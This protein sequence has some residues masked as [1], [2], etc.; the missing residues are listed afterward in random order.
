MAHK[1]KKNAN[2][3]DT[4]N[5]SFYKAVKPFI[6]DHRVLLSLLGAAGVGAALAATLGGEKVNGLVDR[7]SGAIKGFGQHPSGTE[8]KLTTAK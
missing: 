2:K 4:K 6:Q 8:T 7:L 1:K 3:K 5:R